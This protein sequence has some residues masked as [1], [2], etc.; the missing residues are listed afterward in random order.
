MSGIEVVIVIGLVAAAV[1]AVIFL[2]PKVKGVG[3]ERQDLDVSDSAYGNFIPIGRGRFKVAGDLVYARDLIVVKKTTGGGKKPK[4]TTFSYFLDG[5]YIMADASIFGP[6]KEIVKVWADTELIYD[7]TG[8]QELDVKDDVT[9]RFKLGDAIQEPDIMQVEDE[10]TLAQGFPFSVLI[11]LDRF[12][13]K[14]TSDRPPSLSAE[15]DFEKIDPSALGLEQTG[16]DTGTENPDT[17][18][19]N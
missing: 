17:L 12:P 10:G 1:A 14:Y 2:A 13:L 16:P 4:V 18:G 3:G 9:L 5:I 19:N 6:A 11:A 7:V 15:I 8:L